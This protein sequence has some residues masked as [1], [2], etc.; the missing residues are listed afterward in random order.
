MADFW[1]AASQMA[2][3][4]IK[5]YNKTPLGETG[6]LSIFGPPPRFTCTLPWL[7]RLVKVS[8]SSELYPDMRL[9]FLFECL[10][11]QFFNSHSHVTYGT[12]CHARGHSH[13]CLGKQR[14]FIGV[15][16]I[17]NM[18]LCSHAQ[19]DCNQFTIIL[20]LY[21]CM[22]RLEVLLVVTTLIKNIELQS[23]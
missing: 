11:T 2:A 12:P 4:I 15:A 3:S 16:I 14:I 13:S 7:L 17:L 9:F 18:C 8:T 6:C 5:N 22:S 20:H 23:H 1:V 21:L 19:L 10:G